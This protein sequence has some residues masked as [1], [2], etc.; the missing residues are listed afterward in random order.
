MASQGYNA[1]FSKGIMK[2]LLLSLPYYPPTYP[3]F[4]HVDDM[5]SGYV[6]HQQWE[7]YPLPGKRYPGQAVKSGQFRQ[8]FPKRYVPDGYGLLDS[9]PREDIK[10]DLYGL[11]HDVIPR[12]GGLYAESFA[13][14][15]DI[16]TAGMY[17]YY[18][19][20]AGN[21]PYGSDNLSLFNNAHP[22][23]LYN[24]TQTWSNRPSVDV[25][26]TVSTYHAAWTNLATQKAPNNIQYLK[27]RP[28]CLVMHPNQ[29][30]VAEQVLHQ[31]WER[32]TS[33]RNT[34]IIVRDNVKLI[35]WP[36]FTSSGS[37]GAT[38]NP[39][40]YNS[41]MIFGQRHWNRFFWRDT[42]DVQ[43]Q[44]DILTNSE[45]IAAFVRF[46]YGW[47]NPYGCYGSLGL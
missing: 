20:A 4:M 26:L 15:P 39:P 12:R 2:Q 6:D 21:I 3:E 46:A 24:Q 36:Y 33:D 43:H 7:G 41:W 29:R 17:I 27:N 9:F 31:Q 28:Q 18:G 40:S 44:S 23:A 47:D 25:D 38:Y 22:F 30:Q 16:Q 8:S 32:D 10:D 35:L 34:N 5:D 1:I 42:Y 13:S 11:I 19:F 37:V 14:L 45:L